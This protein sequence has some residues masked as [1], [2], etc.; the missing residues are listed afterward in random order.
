MRCSGEP[1]R[2]RRKGELAPK[3]SLPPPSLTRRCWSLRSLH[4]VRN[5]CVSQRA[6][7]RAFAVLASQPVFSV[8]GGCRSGFSA[9]RVCLLF[10]PWLTLKAPPHLGSRCPYTSTLTGTNGART[11]ATAVAEEDAN[12]PCVRASVRHEPRCVPV[13]DFA[14]R[15]L[16][17]ANGHT[18][19]HTHGWMAGRSR[20]R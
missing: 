11:C 20:G 13:D 9:P 8:V 14:A 16:A 15:L 19:T 18:H 5:H 10:L 4:I 17:F 3:R 1:G 2:G 12:D 6:L 7:P